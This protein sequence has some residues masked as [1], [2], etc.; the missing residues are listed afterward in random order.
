MLRAVPET[1]R[2]LFTGQF[3]TWTPYAFYLDAVGPVAKRWTDAGGRQTSQALLQPGEPGYELVGGE[4]VRDPLMGDV[5]AF[6]SD[7]NCMVPVS[8]QRLAPL[9][10][11]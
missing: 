5:F 2:P 8:R 11:P 3:F 10:N 4:L 9:C 1:L 7:W 6:A